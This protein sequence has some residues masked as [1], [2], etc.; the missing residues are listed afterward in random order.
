MGFF[1]ESEVILKLTRTLPSSNH[2]FLAFSTRSPKSLTNAEVLPNTGEI[3]RE[4]LKNQCGMLWVSVVVP[5]CRSWVDHGEH[6]HQDQEIAQRVYCCALHM[7]AILTSYCL[8][9]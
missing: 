9:C 8:L 4:A 1:V 2:M 3:M 6:V 5:F 7:H